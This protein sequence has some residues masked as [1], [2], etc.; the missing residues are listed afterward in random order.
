MIHDYLF[1]LLCLI[2]FLAYQICERFNKQQFYD[3]LNC[4]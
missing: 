3:E 4:K 2:W 1:Y